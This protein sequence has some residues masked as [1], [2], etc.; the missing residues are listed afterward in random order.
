MAINN[1]FGS[2]SLVG[3]RALVTGG[4]GGIGAAVSQALAAAGVHVAINYV[5]NAESAEQLVADIRASGGSAIAVAADVS[6]EDQVL[7]MYTRIDE[8]FG[9]L[10]ILINNDYLTNELLIVFG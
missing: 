10:D 7:A 6:Q 2:A 9:G 8:A 3:Q 5:G 4:N 1:S